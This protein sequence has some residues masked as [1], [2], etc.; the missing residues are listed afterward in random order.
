MMEILRSDEFWLSA[1][2][3]EPFVV[4]GLRFL[5]SCVVNARESKQI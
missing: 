2:V 5:L 1:K 3:N 4:G